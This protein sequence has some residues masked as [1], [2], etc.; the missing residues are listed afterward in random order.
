MVGSKK[1]KGDN[2]EDDLTKDMDDPPTEPSVS[3]VNVSK[4]GKD[5][6]CIFSPED[7]VKKLKNDKHS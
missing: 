7:L 3:E 1:H 5:L 4:P 2:D 6:S